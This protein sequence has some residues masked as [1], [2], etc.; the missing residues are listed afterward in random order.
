MFKKNWIKINR[1]KGLSKLKKRMRTRRSKKL[2]LKRFEMTK[3]S[4]KKKRARRKKP[5]KRN[6]RRRKS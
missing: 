4:V 6:W 3:I 2:W 1:M 5:P